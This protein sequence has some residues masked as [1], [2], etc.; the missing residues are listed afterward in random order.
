MDLSKHNG[1][2]LLFTGASGKLARSLLPVLSQTHQ[3]TAIANR[4]AIPTGDWQ[5]LHIDLAAADLD[6][7]FKQT[8]PDVVINAAALATD[9]QCHDDPGAARLINTVVPERIASICNARGITLIHFSTDQVYDGR[10]G[11]YRET[12]DAIALNTYGQT[13]LE[14]ESHVFQ[15]GA[16]TI[17]LRLALTYGLGSGN[18]LPFSHT[19]INQLRAEERVN[20]FED[21][22]RSVLYLPDLASLLT[23]LVQKP[24][25]IAPGVYNVG[26]LQSV[27]RVEFARA[28]CNRFD[29]SPTLINPIKAAELSFA[30]PRPA[31]CSMNLDKLLSSVHWRPRTL[32]ETIDDMHQHLHRE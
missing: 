10:K 25:D 15:S 30:E 20:L 32:P 17:I 12:D 8:R 27:N 6:D 13:K 9:R 11:D 26:G 19:L 5:P 7:L 2:R 1:R 31:D 3:L 21:E 23:E 28:V 24:T 14:G 18:A 16:Q 22:Y 4:S 29:F